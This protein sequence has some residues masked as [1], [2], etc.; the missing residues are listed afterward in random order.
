[1][2]KNRSFGQKSKIEIFA[3]NSNFGQKSISKVDQKWHIFTM[4]NGEKCHLW[5]II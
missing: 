3:K 5:L 2:D 4:I 1:M